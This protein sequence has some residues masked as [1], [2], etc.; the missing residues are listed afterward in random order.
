[1]VFAMMNVSQ[2]QDLARNPT[3]ENWGTLAQHIGDFLNMQLGNHEREIA[4]GI[5]REMVGKAELEIRQELARRLSRDKNVPH[6]IL[7]M[8]AQDQIVVAEPVLAFSELLTD[9]DLVA[10]VIAHEEGHWQAI[11]GRR[12]V[13]EVV[14]MELA[15]THDGK[16][17]LTLAQNMGAK[18]PA[19]AMEIMVDVSIGFPS[20]RPAL[21][22]RKEMESDL[23]LRIY[24]WVSMELRTHLREKFDYSPERLDQA[25]MEVLGQQI[26]RIDGSEDNPESNEEFACNLLQEG[27]ADYSLM[28]QALRRARYGLFKVLMQRALRVNRSCINAMMTER[29]GESLAIACRSLGFNKAEFVSIYIFGRVIWSG[30][31]KVSADGL[32]KLLDIFERIAPDFA[33][34]MVEGWRK[35]PSSVMRSLSGTKQ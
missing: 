22:Q 10:L 23:G 26:G 9:E 3:A 21:V 4:L 30:G 20:L 1:M 35:D 8:L 28:I 7:L 24:W 15:Q 32:S 5:L 6:D 2:L 27:V 14:S 11:A 34:L 17:L 19:P 12:H 13:S 16:T 25:F 18:I 33:T 29:G 31:Q